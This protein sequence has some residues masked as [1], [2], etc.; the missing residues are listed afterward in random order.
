VSP[1]PVR[2]AG[3]TGSTRKTPPWRDALLGVVVSAPIALVMSQVDRAAYRTGAVAIAFL[4]V[5]GLAI[6][7]RA[8]AAGTPV[9][10][11][12]LWAQSTDNFDDIPSAVEVSGLL[13]FALSCAIVVWA[14]WRWEGDRRRAQEAATALVRN[15]R[16]LTALVDF[17]QKLAGVGDRTGVFRVIADDITATTGAEAALLVG[18]QRD[19]LE[20]L[21]V[22]GYAENS[23]PPGLS[24]EDVLGGTP[25][26]AAMTGG[27]PLFIPSATDLAERYPRLQQY[28]ADMRHE[29][30]AA[31]PVPRIGV[32]VLAWRER[33][34][35][36]RAQRA[37][38]V[39]VGNLVGAAV[40]R[41]DQVAREHLERFAGAFDAMIDGVTIQRAI[42]D[43]SG[44]IVDF[45]IEYINAASMNLQQDRS[46]IVG[47]RLTEVWPKTPLMER[48]AD[49]VETGRPFELED[50]DSADLGGEAETSMIVSLRVSR[51]DPERLVLVVRDSSERAALLREIQ[52]ANRGF[53]VAQELARVGSWRYDQETDTL[54]FSDELYRI[55]GMKRGDELPRPST[56]RLF[57]FEH[58]NDRGRVQKAIAEAVENK[59]PFSFDVR[60]IRQSDGD[61]RDTTTSGIV[62]VDDRDQ[63]TGIWG[64]TQDVTE[65]QRAEQVRRE[66]VGQLVQ[67]RMVV[68]ELQKVLLPAE[69]PEITGA[70]LAA[71][72]RAANIEE[73]VGGDWYDA[74]T[75]PDGRVFMVVGDVAG[76][77][78]SC[79][80]LANQLRVMIRVRVNDGMTAGEILPLA[81]IEL[82]DDFATCWLGAYDSETRMLTVAN[83]G[84]LPAV[85]LRNGRC[86]FVAGHTRPPL[87]AGTGKPEEL[88][89][90]L[91][92]GDV[93]VVFTDGL[94][95]RRSESIEVGLARLRSA[96][97][98]MGDGADP[99]L[100]LISRLAINSEDDVCV[101]TLRVGD[102]G[103]GL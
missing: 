4:G 37:Y 84:H 65:R 90:Q 55:C 102:G 47:R 46:E 36:G 96:I 39:T 18:R 70:T 100:A 85:L 41:V 54:E 71:H 17:A 56:G 3:A 8:S 16:R 86:S 61:V 89:L 31:I 60:I 66:M 94:V 76:H 13:V 74:F 40:Q 30:W 91:Q 2:Q 88:T 58:P 51:L 11:L 43:A 10:L 87:G 75:A 6:S 82:A 20:F 27:A 98:E 68:S 21:V 48:Y 23:F 12:G 83:A 49:V 57:D 80:T 35:F 97:L 59:A 101:L 28:R 29:S 78:I 7:W 14:L 73:A 103:S 24:E 45:E 19:R 15:E 32:L 77:G 38:I 53:S 22:T 67:Q 72:Y 81:D 92:S 9:L 25:A 50:V 69:M 64:A 33:Q 79:A 99:G 63:I 1:E 42:R 93:L 34:S 26:L 44:R 5:L 95:E 62:M 52:E